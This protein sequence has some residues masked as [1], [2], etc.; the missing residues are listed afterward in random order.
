MFHPMNMVKLSQ[1]DTI[2][3]ED[4]MMH[5]VIHIK[6]VLS[7]VMS[8]L[9]LN[10]TIKKEVKTTL[11]KDHGFDPPIDQDH[12]DE[13]VSHPFIDQMECIPLCVPRDQSHI[14]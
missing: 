13:D 7:M 1:Q 11:H 6:M 2:M 10:S 14:S 8:K 9:N 3:M 4:Q 12:D 5:K